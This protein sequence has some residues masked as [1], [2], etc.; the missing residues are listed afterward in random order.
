MLRLLRGQGWGQDPLAAVALKQS[1]LAAEAA[2]HP[3]QAISL[4]RHLLA[5]FPQQPA[6]ADALYALGRSTPRLR[7][8]LLTRFPAH[9]AYA[10]DLRGHGQSGGGPISDW[11]VVARDVATFLD[12][13]GITGAAVLVRQRLKITD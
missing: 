6:S 7:Q 9:P 8:Q 5:R 3:N 4:W 11:K 1:A 13:A 10:I 12:A 2:G